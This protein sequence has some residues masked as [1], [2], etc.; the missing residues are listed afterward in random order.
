MPSSQTMGATQAQ[1]V[2]KKNGKNGGSIILPAGSSYSGVP[3]LKQQL[4]KSGQIKSS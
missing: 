3:Q 4:N 1:K 2:G